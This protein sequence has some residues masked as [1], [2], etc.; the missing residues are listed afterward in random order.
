MGLCG[1]HLIYIYIY[2]YRE[3]ERCIYIYIY[4]YTYI[5]IYIYIYTYIDLRFTRAS[6]LACTRRDSSKGGAAETG[7]SGLHYIIGSFTI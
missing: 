3:R 1:P 7:C 4:I 2:I 6:E 5:H